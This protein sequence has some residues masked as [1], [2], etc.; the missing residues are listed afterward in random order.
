MAGTLKRYRFCVTGCGCKCGVFGLRRLDRRLDRFLLVHFDLCLLLL[1]SR[2]ESCR[3]EMRGRKML[4]PSRLVV[5]LLVMMHI[6]LATTTKPNVIFLMSDDL[7]PELSIYG[8]KH[9]IR[10][11]CL[12]LSYMYHAHISNLLSTNFVYILL[13][14]MNGST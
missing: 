2:R 6:F 13:M 7:R 8:R 12:Y 1:V 9:I 11:S 3:Q 10:C 14:Q 4:S 5:L